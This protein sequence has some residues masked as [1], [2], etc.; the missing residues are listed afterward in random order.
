MI[1]QMFYGSTASTDE[2]YTY[3]GNLDDLTLTLVDFQPA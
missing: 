1:G 3:T 2:I